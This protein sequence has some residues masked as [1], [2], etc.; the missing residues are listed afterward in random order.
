MIC[1]AC[2]KY[3]TSVNITRAHLSQ[4]KIVH[5]LG[6]FVDPI[7]INVIDNSEH[8]VTDDAYLKV[9]CDNTSFVTDVGWI[10]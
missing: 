2:I 4:H 10:A 7:S 5:V 1:K 6:S 8:W 9:N 3:G